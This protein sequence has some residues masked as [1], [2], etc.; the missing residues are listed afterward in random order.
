MRITTVS[1]GL[2]NPS[3]TSNLTK[4][5]V[6]EISRTIPNSSITNYELKEYGHDVLDK[7]FT[8]FSN[9]RLTTLL[10]DVQKSDALVFTTPI[11]NTGPS[12]LFKSFLDILEPGSHDGI[13]VIL[14]A[15]GGT[16]R[17]SLSIDYNIRPITT[18][19][20]MEPITTAVYASS[21]DYAS[22]GDSSLANRISKAVN[23]LSAR[24][25]NNKTV[26]REQPMNEF[27]PANYL[28]GEGRSFSDLLP[29]RN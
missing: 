22:I 26:A 23:E 14:A 25:G 7:M 28:G 8:G 3:S 19:L 17:H 4:S 20:H 11:F 21:S 24:L 16:D 2:S 15:T 5:I 29:Q 10:N 12:G 6:Q 13:P 27:D 9:E 18:Y 1:A